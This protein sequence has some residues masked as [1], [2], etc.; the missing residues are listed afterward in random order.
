MCAWLIEEVSDDFQ[1]KH[2]LEERNIKAT[3]NI[4][5]KILVVYRCAVTDRKKRVTYHSQIL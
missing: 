3:Y 4:Q 1:C 2:R 5:D